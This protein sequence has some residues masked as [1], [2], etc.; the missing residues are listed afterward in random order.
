MN[1]AETSKVPTPVEVISNV[2]FLNL[3]GQKLHNSVVYSVSEPLTDGGEV[4]P[5]QVSHPFHEASVRCT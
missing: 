1:L 4:P 2:T 3:Q 5:L